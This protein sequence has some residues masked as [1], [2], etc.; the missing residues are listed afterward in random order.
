MVGA[1]DRG[2]GALA[3][4]GSPG[5]TRGVYT[6][7]FASS[8]GGRAWAI[9]VATPFRAIGTA[10]MVSTMQPAVE[11]ST[12]MTAAAAKLRLTTVPQTAGR[13]MHTL[14]KCEDCKAFLQIIGRSEPLTHVYHL[15]WLG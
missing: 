4:C 9:V 14:G 2:A 5:G 13:T 10:Y 15:A 1:A 8:T 11:D 6:M 7:Y 3:N 12:S